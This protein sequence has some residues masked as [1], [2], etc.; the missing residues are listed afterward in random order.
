MGQAKFNSNST[1]KEKL[2]STYYHKSDPK[3]IPSCI[4]P[5]EIALEALPL[6]SAPPAP[7]RVPEVCRTSRVSLRENIPIKTA[8]I[9]AR[10]PIAPTFPML[11]LKSRSTPSALRR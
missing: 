10:N 11:L 2:I 5:A 9:K 6:P 3:I 8:N 4:S 7:D 1:V